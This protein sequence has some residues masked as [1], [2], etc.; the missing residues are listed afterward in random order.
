MWIHPEN[1][2]PLCR[3][4]QPRTGI[5]GNS[6]ADDVSLLSAIREAVAGRSPLARG[7]KSDVLQIYD[8]RARVNAM[9]NMVLKGKGT[10]RVAH[11]G[12]DAVSLIFLDIG[13][14][15]VVRA[16][17]NGVVKACSQIVR[18]MSIYAH[19]RGPLMVWYFPTY[20]ATGGTKHPTS[21]LSK[22]NQYFQS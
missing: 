14:I 5:T 10:E 4:A 16:S 13:N 20:P 1:E 15:H 22:V 12:E 8:A 19:S 18:K 6:N 11:Y 9:A 21:D 17:L 3:C 7:A 2:A